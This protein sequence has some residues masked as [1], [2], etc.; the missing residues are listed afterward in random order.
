M[1][2]P[3]RRSPR[4]TARPTSNRGALEDQQVPVLLAVEVD[5]EDELVE[6]PASR[7]LLVE[8]LLELRAVDLVALAAHQ[9]VAHGGGRVLVGGHAPDPTR[10]R[11]PARP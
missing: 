6:L 7:A 4:G 9:A 3:R 11:A 5:V 10:G 1:R 8:D 2:P